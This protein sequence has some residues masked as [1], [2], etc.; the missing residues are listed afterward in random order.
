MAG[1]EESGSG[2]PAGGN[3]PDGGGVG[4]TNPFG[5]STP[6]FRA[7]DRGSLLHRLVPV[8]MH[9][10]D[11]PRGA[12]RP[13]LAA[14]LT[15]AALA[16]PAAMAYAE[17][18]GLSPVAGLYALLLPAVAYALLGSSR[19]LSVGPD[20]ALS[21]L[22]AASLAPFAAQESSSYAFLAA[23]LALLTGGCYYLARVLRLG[24]VAD[25]FSKPVLVGYIHGI[26]IVLI[27]GQLGKILGL[28]IQEQDPVPQVGEVA[29]EIQ[30]TS[31]TTLAVATVSV[32]VLLVLRRFLPRVPGA[33]VVIV[34]GIVAS[35]AFSLDAHGVATVGGIP[36]GLPS[37]SLP[38]VG[39]RDS[40]QLVP[41]ALAVFAVGFAD[42]ILTARSFAGRHGQH[43]RVNQELVAMGSANVGAG[44]TGSFPVTAS[45][46]RTAVNDQSGGKT[47]FVNLVSAAVA[48]LVLLF[49]TGPVAL[50]PKACLGAVILVAAIGLIEPD[51]WKALA[52]AGRGQVAIAVTTLLGVITVGVL[53]ALVIAVALSIIDT[54]AR[55]ATPHDAVLGWVDRLGR[56]ANASLH[57]SAVITPGVVVYRLDDRL[58]F[59]NAEHFHARVLEAIAAAPTVTSWLVLDAE[60]IT[61]IDASGVEALQALL[62]DLERQ[63]IHLMVARMKSPLQAR[64][65]ATG[66]TELIGPAQFQPTVHQAVATCVERMAHDAGE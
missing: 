3:G 30:D 6:A 31:G 64:F 44:L 17:L 22:T 5:G 54:V 43:V 9:L 55:S 21:L 58:F 59:A 53:K 10:P 50:L 23:M 14:G 37:L 29:R 41:A 19:Q 40:L 12:L 65:D 47:Q 66:L 39:L 28:A 62:G 11:Y 56:Y 33:L 36:A 52:A 61:G 46:S 25:Y 1:S 51:A 8:T 20:A 15:V 45:G 13:D 24:W 7:S 49:F 4:A 42:S 18:A 2:P 63:D 57:P 27:V 16:I 26:V 35:A 38:H 34:G 60:S 48:A 32:V